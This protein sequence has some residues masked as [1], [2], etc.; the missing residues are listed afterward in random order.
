MPGI[1]IPFACLF[2][3]WAYL[4]LAD[5]LKVPTLAA[6]KAVIAVTRREKRQAKSLEA[7]IF[8]LAVK[9][10]RF[11]KMTGVMKKSPTP[12]LRPQPPLPPAVRRRRFTLTR[13]TA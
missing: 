7:I 6:T 5:V 10:S 8:D 2:A 11:I 9:L 3:A 1:L 13:A 4:V 12:V